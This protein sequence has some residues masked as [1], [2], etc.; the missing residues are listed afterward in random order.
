M[1][2]SKLARLRTRLAFAA[3]VASAGLTYGRLYYG[4]DFTD[5]AFYTAVPYRFVLG[6]LP[7]VDETNIVQQTPA[8]LLYPVVALWH[9]LVGVDGIVLYARHLHFLFTVGIAGAVFVALRRLL[10]DPISS[11]V[12]ATAV[13]VFVPFGI[14][15]LSYNTFASGFFTAGCF[16]GAAWATERRRG[17][18]VAAGSAQALA[19]FTYPT[20]LLPVACSFALLYTCSRCRSLREL[21]PGL[22]PVAVG[23]LAT[24]LFF[25]HRGVGTIEALVRQTSDVGDQGGDLGELA[26]IVSFVWS[27]FSHKYAVAALLL[28]AAALRAWRPWAAIAPLLLM[29]V[30]V[31]PADL[32]TSATANVF[33]TSIAFLGPFV[34][35]LVRDI[36]VARRLL[37]LVWLPAL[38]AG[39]TTAMSSA[40]GP[41]N[42]AIGFFPGLVVTAVL[43][44]LALRQV[45]WADVA[46]A[47]MLL[48]IGVA[49]QYLS[50]YRDSGIQ[51]LT[52]R[53]DDGPYAGVYTTSLKRDFLA[54]LDRDVAAVAG[55]DCRIVFYDTFPAG[56]LLGHGRPATNSTW[57]LDV[58]DDQEERYQ[59]LLR[60]Y[61]AEHGG[62]PD[63]A[64]RIDSFPLTTADAI[65][66]VYAADEPLERILQGPGYVAARLGDGY[67]IMRA[68][69]S[70]CLQP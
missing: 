38:V 22:L 44:V 13:I 26:D 45:P 64:V 61:Y 21:A 50:V 35:L 18:L 10:G 2:P 40:N 25:L 1:D 20:F 43:L 48:A 16:L 41:I 49:L 70:T 54:R 34:F 29:P 24:V 58:A 9:W 37:V 46:P 68:R 51:H 63:I 12:A 55:P 62:L 4:V 67:R 28:A 32:R 47:A 23:T 8:V 17:P 56:Y 53:V 65:N 69:Q 6:A 42:V 14:H 30:A 57:L 60:D 66:Q 52:T 36:V 19:V 5:E 15:G 7:L 3:V 27:S 11:C 59:R 39:V 31:L 33:V